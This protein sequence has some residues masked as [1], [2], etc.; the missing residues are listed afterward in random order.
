VSLKSHPRGALGA[1]NRSE[2]A[3]QFCRHCHQLIAFGYGRIQRED[4]RESAEDVIT[5]RLTE[6][7]EAGQDERALPDWAEKY[8]VRDQQRVNVPG[9]VGKERP[10]ID[11]EFRSDQSRSRP[12]YHFEAKR[13]RTDDSKSVSQYVGKDGLGMFLA[14]LYGRAG[15]EGGMLGYVQSDSSAHWAEKIGSKLQAGPPGDHRLT[16]DGTWAEARLIAELEH[17]YATRHTR[18]TMANITVYHTLLDF[19]SSATTA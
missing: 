11:I 13:L 19:R 6:A 2:Y 15:D 5:Q 12:L 18:P 7:I 16:A 9:R 10:I 3:A 17:T 1:P 14:E 4:H 8:F